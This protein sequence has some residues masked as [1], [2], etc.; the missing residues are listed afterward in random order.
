MRLKPVAGLLVLF[1]LRTT[2]VPGQTPDTGW[3]GRPK[4][5]ATIQLLPRTGIETWRAPARVELLL[6][7][8]EGRRHTRSSHEADLETAST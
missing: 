5:T 3:E 4:V 8:V 7:E 2:S 6:S 1:A